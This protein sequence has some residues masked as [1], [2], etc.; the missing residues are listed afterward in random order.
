M[1]LFA[2]RFASLIYFVSGGAA[3]CRPQSPRSPGAR[4]ELRS[5]AVHRDWLKFDCA[6][7]YGPVVYL[8]TDA[9]I[10]QVSRTGVYTFI[11]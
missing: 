1:L 10:F 9:R 7:S 11:T 4:G 5:L 2:L 3:R 6:L 8:N